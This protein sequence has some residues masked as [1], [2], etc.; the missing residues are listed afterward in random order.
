VPRSVGS[1][2]RSPCPGS[3]GR[4]R[5]VVWDRG[6]SRQQADRV[7][8][9]EVGDRPGRHHLEQDRVGRTNPRNT[10]NRGHQVGVRVGREGTDSN[11]GPSRRKPSKKISRNQDG[12]VAEQF[13]AA[14]TRGVALSANWRV[15]KPRLRS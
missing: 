11:C 13:V 12:L 15:V 10:A 2:P 4:A 6:R 8:G 1:T 14:G 7:G 5:G 9:V 3:A